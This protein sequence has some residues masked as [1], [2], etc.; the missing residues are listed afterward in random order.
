[1]LSI[2]HATDELSR[3]KAALQS[4]SMRRMFVLA[5]LSVAASCGGGPMSPTVTAPVP[6]L[7]SGA[8]ILHVSIGGPDSMGFSFCVGDFGPNLGVLATNVELQHTGNT[9][10]IQPD[11]S[12]ATFRMDLQMSGAG[13]SG[14]ASGQF[15]VSGRVF[16]VAGQGQSPAAA[17][18][19]ARS[20]GAA[21]NL[22]G[23]VSIS[24]T[25]SLAGT[26]SV[27]SVP[28]LGCN[29]GNWSVTPR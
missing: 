18:G 24:G 17:V 6:S 9:V 26:G 11:D 15:P 21:G 1:L 20:S 5:A 10:T 12:T 29:A 13:L 16:A 14:T 25:I 4:R 7:P 3:L 8:Y 19:T 28:G 2:N 22:T 23:N 27:V